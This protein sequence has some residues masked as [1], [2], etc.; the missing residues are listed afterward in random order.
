MVITNFAGEELIYLDFN[1]EDTLSTISFVVFIY[2]LSPTNQKL[3][4]F[5]LYRSWAKLHL[6]SK[7]PLADL[8]K[9]S[10]AWLFT[11]ELNQ[12]YTLEEVDASSGQIAADID[13][14][15]IVHA[16]N[17]D[18]KA[19][20]AIDQYIMAGKNTIIYIDPLYMKDQQ[21]QNRF[22]PP[23]SDKSFDKLFKK[24]GIEYNASMVACDPIIAF[25]Q[26]SPRGA[27]KLPFVL[28]ISKKNVSEDDMATSDLNNLRFLYPGSFDLVKDTKDVSFTPLI[29]STEE[30][31]HI[32]NFRIRSTQ[33]AQLMNLFKDG[34]GKQ[35]H[36]AGLFSGNSPQLSTKPPK[37]SL[38]TISTKSQTRHTLPL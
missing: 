28:D 26:R 14:L 25:L 16:K 3:A 34:E 27:E 13:L 21:P 7:I 38:E 9:G 18:E 1:S 24:W 2:F 12:T 37:A 36:L 22:Q 6:R 19:Q 32:D 17:L 20:Y 33:P 11:N 35:L 10:P 31:M 4:S 8:P 23:T 30:G 29:S 5:H 15:L